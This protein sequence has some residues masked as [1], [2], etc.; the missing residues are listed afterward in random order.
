M[1]GSLGQMV[2]SLEIPV[3]S[4]VYKFYVIQLLLVEYLHLFLAKSLSLSQKFQSKFN[5]ILCAEREGDVIA[6]DGRCKEFH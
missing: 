5:Q 2:C 3:L 6:R 4:H 1:V